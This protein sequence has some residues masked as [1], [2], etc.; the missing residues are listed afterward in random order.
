MMLS[1]WRRRLFF[2]LTLLA[3]LALPAQHFNGGRAYEY[4]RDFAAIGP[5]WPTSPATQKLKPFCALISST[6][7]LKKMPSSPTHPSAP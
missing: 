5:R 7:S 6:I 1:A 2:V 3:P 4:A